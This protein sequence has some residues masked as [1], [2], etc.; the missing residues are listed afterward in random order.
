MTDGPHKSLPMKV[1]W[2]RV[3]EKASKEAFAIKEVA[4]VLNHALISEASQQFLSETK[5]ILAANMPD[6]LF[7]MRPE[8]IVHEF[9]EMRTKFPGTNFENNFLDA[10]LGAV[11]AGEPAES[12]LI[13]AGEYALT[14]EAQNHFRGIEEHWLR[15]KGTS[16]TDNIRQRLKNANSE[17]DYKNL[18]KIIFGFNHS[19]PLSTR[20]AKHRG[21]DEGVP[22]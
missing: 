21:I 16:D 19:K 5:R 18:S 10:I 7:S 9:T 17:V 11:K 2:K 8:E 13:S 20:P 6:A 1:P 3:A 4:E 15:K 14:Q 22:L 12:L